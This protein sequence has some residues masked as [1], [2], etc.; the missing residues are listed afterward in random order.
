MSKQ[1][2]NLP[3]IKAKEGSINANNLKN[4]IQMMK[5]RKKT[6]KGNYEEN[7]TIQSYKFRDALSE[8]QKKKDVERHFKM[9]TSQDERGIVN[10]SK[11]KIQRENPNLERNL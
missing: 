3:K 6:T 4:L 11:E 9:L 10:I 7:S 2:V 8:R 1:Y 5:I